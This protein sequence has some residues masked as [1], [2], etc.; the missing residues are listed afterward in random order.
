MKEH[1]KC[2]T[3]SSTMFLW[4][5]PSTTLTFH[6]ENYSAFEYFQRIFHLRTSQM[7]L[8]WQ[9]I[10]FKIMRGVFKHL[11]S[12]S[13]FRLHVAIFTEC[14][15]DEGSLED[16]CFAKAVY[17]ATSV[18]FG[19]KVNRPGYLFLENFLRTWQDRGDSDNSLHT[20]QGRLNKMKL[21]MANFQ[22]YD[23]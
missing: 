19:V 18:N 9:K 14:H 20:A 15:Q 5:P 17:V 2:C 3:T 11:A 8:S 23:W 16:D 13:F 10:A 21:I 7:L 4:Q 1:K 22:S 12:A 6:R